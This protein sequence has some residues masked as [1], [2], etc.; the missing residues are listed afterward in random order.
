MHFIV[1]YYP[2]GIGVV[3]GNHTNRRI[4][5]DERH[6]DKR[7]FTQLPDE[8]AG[9]AFT[10]NCIIA[11]AE[12]PP[13]YNAMNERTGAVDVYTCLP[14]LQ[15][16]FIRALP[17]NNFI[18]NVPATSEDIM[19]ANYLQTFRQLVRYAKHTLQHIGFFISEEQYGAIKQI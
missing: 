15:T 2:L 8:M 3:D 19:T 13:G 9:R 4:V 11:V 5:S 16:E 10:A 18:T 6:Y 7:A 14:H 12:A 1:R 17:G